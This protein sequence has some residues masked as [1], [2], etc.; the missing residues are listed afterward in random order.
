MDLFFLIAKPFLFNLT[1]AVSILLFLCLSIP[2]LEFLLTKK[3]SSKYWRKF[4]NTIIIIIIITLGL[5][6]RL[7]LSFFRE[8]NVDMRSWKI[9]SDL[10]VDGKN[11]Y[12]A[13]SLYGYFPPWIIVLEWL[14]KINKLFPLIS[15][16]FVVKLFLTL[17][18]CLTL[19][20]LFLIARLN[21]L[22]FIS[23]A[24]LFFLNPIS[25]IITGYHGQFEGL[26]VLFIL[27]SLYIYQK[28]KSFWPAFFIVILGGITK[29][30]FYNQVIIFLRE[31]FHNKRKKIIIYFLISLGISFL[32]L[33]PYWIEGSKYVIKYL[34][35]YSLTMDKY[36]F[37]RILKNIGL[38]KYIDYYKYFFALIFIFLP[39]F[40]NSKNILQNSLLGTLLFIVFGS[41]MCD[42][43]MV[44][45]VALGALNQTF[46]LYLYTFYTSIYYLGSPSEFDIKSWKLFSDNTIWLIALI[47]FIYE[48]IKL[49]KL[50]KNHD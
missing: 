38:I 5:Y 3:I 11:I 46:G 43:Y 10:A 22:N 13:S 18:D 42:Q 50:P 25:I 33:L 28:K 26:A 44:I 45:P 30:M 20:T 39:I 16:H 21:K 36:G 4:I 7:V 35:T 27:L 34:I 24:S 23:I 15:F 48:M 8:G 49:I 40:F 6:A 14:G 12:M 31:H 37:V 2:T 1:K 32:T 9:L 47:W 41:A 29:H 17:I 19:Y